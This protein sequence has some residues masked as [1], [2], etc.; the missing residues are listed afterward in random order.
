[1]LLFS[2]LVAR[3]ENKYLIILLKEFEDALPKLHIIQ[4]RVKI[5]G[6]IFKP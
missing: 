6:H 3:E 5:N 1:M 4:E 2:I